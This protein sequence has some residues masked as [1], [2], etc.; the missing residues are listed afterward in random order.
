M[1]KRLLVIIGVLFW[2]QVYSTAQAGVDHGSTKAATFNNMKNNYRLLPEESWRVSLGSSAD[3]VRIDV[4]ITYEKE[5][6]FMVS[7]GQ[8]VFASGFE[9]CGSHQVKGGSVITWLGHDCGNAYFKM[10]FDKLKERVRYL[11]FSK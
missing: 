11:E 4:A 9:V 3:F 8:R 5:G 1:L 10:E 6:Y 2:L 7:K